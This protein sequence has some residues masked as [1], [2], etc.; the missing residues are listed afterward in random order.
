[1]KKI[2]KDI[3][4]ILIIV[5]LVSNAL[6]YYNSLNINKI[7]FELKNIKLADGFN[8]IYTKGKPLLVYFWS[9]D[10]FLCAIEENTIE[11][12]SQEYNVLSVSVNSGY[13]DSV[14][15]YK[16]ENNLT[17][18]VLNDKYKTIYKKYNITKFPTTIIYDK[19]QKFVFADVGYTS[20]IA[21][22]L[23]MWW[24]KFIN[25]N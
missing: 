3:A 25:K 15:R 22:K 23:R 1:M 13:D 11:K 5:F 19:N 10:C 8:F 24:A 20:N 16:N 17:F 4:S 9:K 7:D 14:I 2:L 12:L 18:D 6:S 21:L